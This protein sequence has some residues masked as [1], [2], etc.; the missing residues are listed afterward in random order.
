MKCLVCG[1]EQ[2]GFHPVLWPEL[3]DDWQLSVAEAAYVDRQQGEHCIVCR[4]NLRSIALAKGILGLF[5]KNTLLASLVELPEFVHSSVLEVNE[6]G[7]LSP[8]LQKSQ[9]YTYAA[10]PD[11]DMHHLPY[12]DNSFDLVVHSDTL[13]HVQHPEHALAECRRVLRPGGALCFTVPVIVGRMSRNREGLKKSYH[14]N[15]QQSPD[16]YLVHTEFG[17]DAWTSL[18]RAGFSDVRIHAV[19]YP[20]AIALVGV[21]L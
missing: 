8:Y 6:A 21:K 20:A 18:F 15:S 16:D 12:S 19:E 17:A 3:I 7:T 2:F 11:V 4:A 1:G 5:G 14:G 10:Y 9:F 13:E